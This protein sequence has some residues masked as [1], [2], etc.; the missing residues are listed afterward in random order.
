LPHQLLGQLVQQLLIDLLGGVSRIHKLKA[1]DVRYAKADN[2][3][4]VVGRD[5]DGATDLGGVFEDIGQQFVGVGVALLFAFV[6]HAA[7]GQALGDA[8]QVGWKVDGDAVLRDAA[9]LG[10]D[11]PAYANVVVRLGIA[12]HLFARIAAKVVQHQR[13]KLGFAIQAVVAVG[14]GPDDVE[15]SAQVL[16]V[17]VGDF[18][19]VLGGCGV[20]CQ[21]VACALL[22]VLQDAGL[23]FKFAEK[24]HNVPGFD[25]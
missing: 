6:G 4:V 3:P 13:G 14:R 2:A 17:F 8:L 24:A 19:S 25:L 18:A 20:G 12:Q 15:L 21:V 5:E 10:H 9:G 7:C 16:Q 1:T 23:V 22:L 11:V